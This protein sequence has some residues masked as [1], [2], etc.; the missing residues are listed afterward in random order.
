VH[1]LAVKFISEK[2][3]GLVEHFIP[4][5]FKIRFRFFNFKT[6]TSRSLTL[7]PL[8]KNTERLIPLIATNLGKPFS[9]KF[10]VHDEKLIP[11]FVD[12]LNEQSLEIDFFDSKSQLTFA[13]A[14]VPLHQMLSCSRREAFV[15][16]PLKNFSTKES[17]EEF[18][19]L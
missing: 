9:Q 13:R 2:A 4:N 17:S 10:L 12:Y 3:E 6:V 15:Q 1:F 5:R 16:V 14:Q 8:T 19:H 18:A 7:D 11:S